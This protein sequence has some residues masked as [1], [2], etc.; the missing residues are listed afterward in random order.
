MNPEPS[1]ISPDDLKK[2]LEH[3]RQTPRPY[4]WVLRVMR[5]KGM[6]LRELLS[7]DPASSIDDENGKIMVYSIRT[8]TKRIVRVRP[9]LAHALKAYLTRHPTMTPSTVHYA[10]NKVAAQHGLRHVKLHQVHRF[11]K[12]DQP[13]EHADTKPADPV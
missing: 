10:F 13:I 5:E 12:L 8:K 1:K 9:K 7:L 11:G 4:S 2:L 3:L 6:R